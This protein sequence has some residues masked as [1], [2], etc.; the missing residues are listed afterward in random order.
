VASDF[1][2]SLRRRL[3]SSHGI[4]NSITFQGSVISGDNHIW[5]IAS[6]S[7]FLPGAQ[8]WQHCI[9][10]SL[11]ADMLVRPRD[12]ADKLAQP[13]APTIIRLPIEAARRKAREIVDQSSHAGY[14]AVVEN[15]RQLPDGRIEFTMRHLPTPD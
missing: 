2:S 1:S 10:K 7:V 4:S 5:R 15:W 9:G 3:N 11:E 14:A 13:Q 8:D 12:L 6:S